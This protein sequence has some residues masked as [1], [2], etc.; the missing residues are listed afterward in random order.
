MQKTT[1][2]LMN[3]LKSVTDV[4][5]FLEENREEILAHSLSDYLRQLLKKYSLD[6]SQVFARA[7]MKDN[8]YGYEI[9]RNDKKRASRDKLIQ[10]CIGFPLTIEETQKVLRYGKVSP[11]YPR[12]V[13]DALILYGLK[14]GYDVNQLNDLLFQNGEEVFE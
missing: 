13:R 10:I 11:L 8:N 14:K 7:G 9:F 1:N 2:E 5:R 12:D 3:E 4:D 6:K